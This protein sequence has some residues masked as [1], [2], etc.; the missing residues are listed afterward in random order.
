MSAKQIEQHNLSSTASQIFL[1]FFLA[2]H[3]R[4][5]FTHQAIHHLLEFVVKPS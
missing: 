5:P 2:G 3:R 4:H 1:K